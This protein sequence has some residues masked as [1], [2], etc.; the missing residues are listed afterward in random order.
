MEIL[1]YSFYFIKHIEGFF[2]IIY[3]LFLWI[4]MC[5][6]N[7]HILEHLSEKFKVSPH[8]LTWCFLDH[9]HLYWFL[10][11]PCDLS[12]AAISVLNLSII[13]VLLF[14]L[15]YIV[16][17][18]DWN[19]F[20]FAFIFLLY[21]TWFSLY[22]SLYYVCVYSTNK[23]IFEH[24]LENSIHLKGDLSSFTCINMT[25][26][27]DLNSVVLCFLWYDPIFTMF[28]YAVCFFLLFFKLFWYL[29]N[30]YFFVSLAFIILFPLI[31]LSHFTFHRLLLFIS[32][33]W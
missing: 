11:V 3:G 32:F 4:F 23:I 10:F 28:L 15:A 25:N 1:W 5:G 13:I 14:I 12:W 18:E 7:R 9:P 24:Q 6:W 17:Y 8:D 29:W 33:E 30:L 20:W 22:E 2:D 31:L 16:W 27:G 19:T 26:I 21:F